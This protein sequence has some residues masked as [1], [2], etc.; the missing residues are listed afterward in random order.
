M[1]SDCIPWFLCSHRFVER[2]SSGTGP[3]FHQHR[4]AALVSLWITT[5]TQTKRGTAKATWAMQV[6]MGA[7]NTAQEPRG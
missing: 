2:R 6:M 7:V 5:S 4:N 3:G 1:E